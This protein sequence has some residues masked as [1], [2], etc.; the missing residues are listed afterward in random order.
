MTA[1]A[2]LTLN[3]AGWSAGGCSISNNVATCQA[4]SLAAQSN[5]GL[6]L[7]ITGSTAGDRSYTIAA[8]SAEA[9]RAPANNEVSGQVTVSSPPGTDSGSG[10]GGSLGWLTLLFLALAGRTVRRRDQP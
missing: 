9:D 10:G 7:G 6:Q 1:Q 8:N 5:I 4:N 2:G 3:S